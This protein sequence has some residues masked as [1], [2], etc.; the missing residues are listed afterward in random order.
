MTTFDQA[1]ANL[2]AN[3]NQMAA[4]AKGYNV[5][6]AKF[7]TKKAQ[8]L[9]RLFLLAGEV[10][11]DI[12]NRLAERKAKEEQ[13]EKLWGDLFGAGEPDLKLK[14]EIRAVE[15][16]Q[17]NA[18][19]L[20][21]K[22]NQKGITDTHL[23]VEG[24]QATGIGD[25]AVAA[26]HVYGIAAEFTASYNWAIQ[27]D[28]RT[29]LARTNAHPN[30]KEIALNDTDLTRDEQF[31]RLQYLQ[32][33]F[34]FQRV[35]EYSKEFLTYSQADGGSGYAA[36][37]IEQGNTIKKNIV[38]NINIQ[39]GLDSRNKAKGI[40]FETSEWNEST[41]KTAVSLVLNSSNEE[42]TGIMRRDK[43]WEAFHD[44]IEDG[45]KT[46]NITREEL[47]KIVDLEIFNINGKKTLAEHLPD[48]YDTGKNLDGA[49]GTM[50]TEA[51]D[52]VAGLNSD[53]DKRNEN[54]KLIEL[55]AVAKDYEAGDYYTINAAGEEEINERK[56]I[57]DIGKICKDGRC[58]VSEEQEKILARPTKYTQPKVDKMLNDYYASDYKNRLTLDLHVQSFSPDVQ[59]HETVVALI[60]VQNQLIK[61]NEDLFN[62]IE[63][64]FK[65]ITVNEGGNKEKDWKHPSAQTMWKISRGRFL[66]ILED[67][68]K[69]TDGTKKNPELL[70]REFLAQLKEDQKNKSI[71]SQWSTYDKY[72]NDP[73]YDINNFG[74]DQY[75]KK[76]GTYD[77]E[78]H[79]EWLASLETDIYARDTN[80]N[81]RNATKHPMLSGDYNTTF[82]E[83]IENEKTNL[84]NPNLLFYEQELVNKSD[85][86]TFDYNE[87]I[88]N[89]DF[90]NIENSE[91]GEAQRICKAQKKSLLECIQTRANALN[92]TLDKETID[93][94]SGGVLGKD[95]AVDRAEANG[96][97]YGWFTVDEFPAMIS[98]FGDFANTLWIDQGGEEAESH[99]MSWSEVYPNLID[100]E[101][102]WIPEFK[103]AGQT[104]LGIDIGLLWTINPSA[105]QDLDNA[106]PLWEIF[107]SIPPEEKVSAVINNDEAS[108][109]AYRNTG[110]LALVPK[111]NNPKLKDKIEKDTN[112]ILNILNTNRTE[113]ASLTDEDIPIKSEETNQTSFQPPDVI[114]DSLNTN[115]T[116]T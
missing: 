8:D 9:S 40:L 65:D 7:E 24:I 61:D 74:K 15:E 14:N 6:V 21:I 70:Q 47:E 85:K 49:Q 72:K 16:G 17:L 54:L 36:S 43:A 64:A 91:L 5:D 103:E 32:K 66:K 44:I 45:V 23:T 55:A 109:E 19:N 110:I 102:K 42:G 93:K 84:N 99:T 116:T 56:L 106:M 96:N 111:E 90:S 34:T 112:S 80:F 41:L 105:K 11:K 13:A 25:K 37:L 95:K 46:G 50:F 35:G 20:Y 63:N 86:E 58:D 30:G 100:D 75:T 67:N 83:E 98:K 29:F 27:N 79:Q 73:K 26:P 69:L 3:S 82:F 12:S 57:T 59:K 18:T 104:M 68:E 81:Y 2:Q 51:D 113:I 97:Q 107:R 60:D 48:V 77:K 78:G 4:A 53:V 88:K 33:E 92:Q 71:N 39:S 1:L 94:L 115:Y 52:Y 89:T 31:A 62:N 28:T 76:D 87:V 101:G 114:G 10:G 108:Y 38:K 22:A